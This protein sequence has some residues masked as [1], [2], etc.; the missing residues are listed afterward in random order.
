MQR[1]EDRIRA[2]IDDLMSAAAQ[3]G[4]ELVIV[5]NEVGQGV[6]PAYRMGRIFV[7]I[8]GRINAHIAGCADAVYLMAAGLSLRLK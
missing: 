7:D 1:L 3:D 2:D 6:I 8:S 4:K 5:T